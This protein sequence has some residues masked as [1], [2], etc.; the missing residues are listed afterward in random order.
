MKGI[1]EQLEYIDDS[2][3]LTEADLITF[4]KSCE[5]ASDSLNLKATEDILTM[6]EKYLNQDE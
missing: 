1:S 4:T 3:N 2:T 5:A 6:I